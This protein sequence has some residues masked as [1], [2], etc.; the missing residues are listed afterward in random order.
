NV[1]TGLV[2]LSA[3][4]PGQVI[5]RELAP[6]EA[7]A[8][9]RG[10]L[11]GLT[12]VNVRGKVVDEQQRSDTVASAV[13]RVVEYPQIVT[14]A[15]SDPLRCDSYFSLDV[16]VGEMVTFS[17]G[18]TGFKTSLSF[19]HRMEATPLPCEADELGQ[20]KITSRQDCQ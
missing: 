10:E 7:G 13:I 16:P 3:V 19:T 4:G 1:P 9:T 8:V 11:R 17:A 20:T 12:L 6:S 15:G 14:V 2:T 5:R 18:H